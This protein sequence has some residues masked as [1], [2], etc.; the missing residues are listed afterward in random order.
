MEIEEMTKKEQAEFISA[1]M[2]KLVE[3]LENE[4]KTPEEIR[5]FMAQNFPI[6]QWDDLQ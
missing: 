5:I 1:E 3:M 4:G 6:I 2:N